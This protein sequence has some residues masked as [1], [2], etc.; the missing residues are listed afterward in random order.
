M[1]NQPTVS[2]YAQKVARQLLEERRVW[3]KRELPAAIAGVLGHTP[4]PRLV[5]AV[6]CALGDALITREKEQG[7]TIME[8]VEKAVDGVAT[9][10]IDWEAVHERA[11]NEGIT[12]ATFSSFMGNYGGPIKR[13]RAAKERAA[14]KPAEKPGLT[15]AD[16]VT[17]R[18]LLDEEPALEHDLATEPKLAR[19][20][21]FD[22]SSDGEGFPSMSVRCGRRLFQ[23]SQHQ[24]GVQLLLQG[25]MTFEEA[26]AIFEEYV[27]PGLEKLRD[28][29][30]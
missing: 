17:G 16:V 9:E 18:E 30:G 22:R 2:R 19:R 12:T 1:R 14:G 5:V 24:E 15:V 4:T 13:R 10:A 26:R 27:E 29:S 20:D 25:V 23:V 6:E 21:G 28:S 8:W 3:L 7:M 11:K